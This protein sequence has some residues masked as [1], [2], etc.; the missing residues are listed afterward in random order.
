MHVASRSTRVEG[1]ILAGQIV[2]G[3]AVTLT[4]SGTVNDL[5]GDLP[6]A[7]LANSGTNPVYILAAAPDNYDRPVDIRQYR[8]GWKV[9]S[10]KWLSTGYVDPVTT[11]TLYKVGISNL[12]NPTIPSGFLV[13]C[14]RG[15]KYTIPS[16]CYTASDNIKVPGK[17]I[18][19]GTN[20]KWQYTAS[21][22]NAVGE[23]VD[24]DPANERLTI[25]IW[26]F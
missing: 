26:S 17:Y 19:V 5:A 20:G 6:I 13:N 12:D 2:E 11:D 1:A 9:V 25:T 15:G 22:T 14:H 3:L 10:D 4:N 8:A 24:Y 23:V 21:R 18:E 16:D 7:T